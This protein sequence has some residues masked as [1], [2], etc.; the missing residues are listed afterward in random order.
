MSTNLVKHTISTKDLEALKNA[1][2]NMENINLAMKGLNHLGN[3]IESGIQRIPAKQQ[4]WIQE[5]VNKTLL[6]VVKANLTTMQKGRPFKK[7]SNATYKTLVTSSG[8][9]GGAFGAPAFAAD[10]TVSTKFMMRSILD[11]ARSEGEDIMNIDT[12]LACLQ[13][14]ALGGGS[15]DDD[16]METSYYTTRIALSSSIKGAS[17]YM[18]N[19]GMSNVLEN[20]LK[21]SANPILKLIGMVASRFSVQVS[22]KFIAQ[23]IPVAGAIGGGSLNF[24]F[25]QHFQ[26]MAK[27]HFT[28][29]KL[30]RKYSEA[31]VKEL[32]E[33]IVIN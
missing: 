31:V 14:F 23:A 11:I 18:V 27:A 32:Y 1:K 4:Q 20:I 16:G 30:E 22:E 8:I 33:K 7:A 10:L 26:Q 6:L 5:L 24:V 17:A 13:V 15:K 25:L 28:I 9:L 3:S 21:T 12:Q 29:R 19:T 2:A